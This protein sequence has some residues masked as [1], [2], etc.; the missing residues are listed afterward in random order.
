LR[1]VA[2]IT[3]AFFLFATGVLLTASSADA[4]HV[5]SLR[6]RIN[7][8]VVTILSG[9]RDGDALGIVYDLSE[10]LDDGDNLRVLPMVG[11]G[12]AQNIRDVLLLTGVDMGIAHSNL[13]NHYA[14]TGE[15]GDIKERLTYV[16]KLFNEEMHVIAASNINS[17]SDLSGQSVNF[18]EVG[19]GTQ[20]T[21]ELVFQALGIKVK[22]VNMGQAEAVQA[23]SQGKIAA[24]ILITGKPSNF[25]RTLN[26][27][28]GLKLIPIPF[29]KPLVD[30]YYP[31]TLTHA[32]YPKLIGE[33]EHVDTIA[34]C[35]VIIAFNWPKGSSRYLKVARFVDAFFN[36]FDEF[37]EPP[38]RP[39]WRDVNFAATLEGWKRFPEAQAWIDAAKAKEVAQAAQTKDAATQAE[40]NRF[41]ASRGDNARV[42]TTAQRE[43]LFR[44]FLKWKDAHAQ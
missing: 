44:A 6:E 8:A 28:D 29:S 18:G 41:M 7:N 21:S 22:E 14:K 37:R 10:V 31:A 32:D 38:H 27:A 35:A 34:N 39:K 16:A 36:H 24:T 2:Q 3:V 33:N 25:V 13:L 20:A 1:F 4:E 40:F 5:P 19:S 9:N 23:I 26:R 30:D 17:F 43:A 42:Q 15:L 11:K 12:S